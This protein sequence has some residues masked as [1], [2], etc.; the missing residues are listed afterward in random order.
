MSQE[1]DAPIQEPDVKPAD[2]CEV[3][4][5]LG[6]DGQ[7]TGVEVVCDTLEARA[8]MATAMSDHDVVVKVRV[9]EEVQPEPE[10]AS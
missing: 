1:N 4:T 6:S 2:V 9:S 7:V 3:R 8:A 5:V 10:K